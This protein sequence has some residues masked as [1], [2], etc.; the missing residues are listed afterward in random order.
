MTWKSSLSAALP[1]MCWLATL[2]GCVDTA[3][4]ETS[5][6]APAAKVSPL[7]EW[8]VSGSMPDP[9]R[10]A[11]DNLRSYVQVPAGSD[12]GQLTIDLGKACLFNV[13]VLEHGPTQQGHARRVMVLTSLDGREYT[14]RAQV[15]GTPRRTFIAILTPTLARYVQIRAVPAENRPWIVAEV[16]LQ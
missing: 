9:G 2:C 4:Q 1:A 14:S 13:V 16:Y 5:Q 10:A 7:A 6:P 11:D 12:Q 8:T 15:P 3:T